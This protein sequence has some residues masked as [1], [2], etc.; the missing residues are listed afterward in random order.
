MNFDI[1]FDRL[2]G[3]EGGYVNDPNDPGGET[4]WG[5]SKRSYSYLDIKNLTR[6]QAKQIYFDD[7]WVP[8][9]RGGLFDSVLFQMF[10]FAVNSGI[11]NAIHAMQ[12]AVGAVPDGYWGP[13]SAR[14]ASEKSE[15]DQ[16]MLL[17]CERLYFMSGL[18]NWKHHGKGWA[19]RIADNLRYAAQD[20]I[21]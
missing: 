6:D 9:T 1:A 5:I 2:L 21:D 17:V 16:L 7:F 11:A 14:A 20:N 13:E 8:V 10:D 18:R 3:H 19:R 12:R 15:A 4:N